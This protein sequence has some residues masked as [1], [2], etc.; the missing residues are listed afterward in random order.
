MV[1]IAVVLAG[2]G[3][4]VVVGFV[5][6]HLKMGSLA[7]EMRDARSRDAHDL[8]MQLDAVTDKLHGLR[9][10]LAALRR[11]QEQLTLEVQGPPSMRRPT[12]PPARR[13]D[14]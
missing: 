6:L 2:L 8:G 13:A 11:S 3:I 10:D 5:G 12:H 1:F 7:D 14:E 4:L 9:L